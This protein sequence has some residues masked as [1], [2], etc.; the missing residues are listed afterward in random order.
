MSLSFSTKVSLLWQLAVWRWNWYRFDT[1]KTYEVAGNPKF[2]SARDA[3]RLIKDG[4]VVAY[5]GIAGNTW[6]TVINFAIKELF[7]EEAHPCDLTVLAIAALGARGRAPGSLE[8][9]AHE[10]LLSRLFTAH[11]ETYKAEL[12]Q[13]DAGKLELQCIPQG[14]FSLILDAM[15]RGENSITNDTGV[16]TFVDPR[17]G[18]GTPVVGDYPQYVEAI[19]GR[20]KYT[21]PFVDVAIINAPAADKK[22]NIYIKNAAMLCESREIVRA[23][24]HN[25]GVVI[26]NVGLI[27]DEGYDEIFI[28]AEDVDAIV[29]H[30]RTEQIGGVPH[31][32][33]HPFT[34]LG[35]TMQIDEALERLTYVGRLL[36]YTPRRRPADNALGRL[37]AT[38]FSGAARKGCYVDI[39]VGLPEEMTRLL[40]EG[41]LL[42]ELNV[43]TESGV[44][45]GLPTPGVHFGAA[46]NPTEIVSSAEAFRRIYDHLDAVVLGALEVDSDGNVNVSK[47]GEGAIN[48]V[49]PG[50]FIDLTT[51][52]RLIVF[53]ASW[54]DGSDI[55]IEDGRI[56]IVE[57]GKPKFIDQVDE[58]TFN[59]QQALEKNKLVYYITHVGAFQLTARGMELI[60]LM[61][62][63]DMQKDIIDACPMKV[64]LPESGEV[65][66]ADASIITGEGFRL[67]FKE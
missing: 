46:V 44:L 41:G 42:N 55:R 48:Y 2:M 4:S 28:P 39:G 43:M 5:S 45:G 30:P 47:R 17:C 65:P 14:T 52:A 51:S 11:T 61:P 22:G 18:R 9:L 31:K 24:C 7:Q 10:G 59:G 37:A 26:V 20:L 15:G 38:V 57:P 16:G 54:G 1:H 25:K 63:I 34:T 58:I 56:R 62:G 40:H 50:G 32:S 12:R 19:D 67:A 36:G 3:V 33:H 6:T 66:T 64:V 35:S 13:A 27:V 60:S 23:A 8:E 49:G 29:I 53:C 21:V